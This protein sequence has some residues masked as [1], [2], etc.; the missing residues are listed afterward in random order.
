MLL[1]PVQ[2]PSV[3]ILPEF[4]ASEPGCMAWLSLGFKESQDASQEARQERR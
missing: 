1:Y 2:V 4:I 3:G